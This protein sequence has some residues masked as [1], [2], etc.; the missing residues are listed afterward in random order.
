[1]KNSTAL[2]LLLLFT[3]SANA[4]Q[5]F[6]TDSV[7]AEDFEKGFGESAGI[8]EHEKSNADEDRLKIGGTLAS[9]GFIYAFEGRDHFRNPNTLWIYLDAK[10]R[11]DIRAFA[12]FKG[13]VDSTGAPGSPLASS[14]SPSD[15]EELKLFFNAHKKVFFTLGKQK[16]K[17]GSGQFWN[18]SDVLNNT[19]RDLLYADDRRSGVSL[20]K[21]HVPVANSNLYL[22]SSFDGADRMSQ[23]GNTLR[24]EVPVATSEISLTASKFYEQETVFGADLSAGLGIIDVRAEAAYSSASNKPRYSAT[25]PF[26]EGGAAFNWVAGLSYDLDYLDNDTLSF[27]VEYFN[28]DDGY[29]KKSDYVFALLNKA[30]VPFHLGEQYAMFMIYAPTPGTWNHTSLSL[31]NVFNLTDESAITK[32]N[33]S[34]TL[35]QDLALDTGISIP[36]GASDREFRMLKQKYELSTRLKVDF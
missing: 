30:Y 6:P 11:N 17:W 18:P 27:N 9:D 23:I 28:N 32:F 19:P 25:G 34:F 7:S 13:V 22:L 3:S 4:Q 21:A 14:V 24:L 1:M 16:V 33:V 8:S 26:T 2:A 10:L 12:K 20:L 35:M 5:E 31:F 15:V 29:D 36:Y